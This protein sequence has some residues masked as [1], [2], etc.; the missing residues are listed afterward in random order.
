MCTVK[1][2]NMN[3][4]SSKNFNMVSVGNVDLY[5]SY[6]TVVAFR[7]PKYNLV[8]VENSWGPTTGK[9]LNWIDGGTDKDKRLPY[10]VFDMKLR[11]M[12]KEHGLA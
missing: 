6:E 8:V 11:D 12:L 1:L 3:Q 2:R 7:A 10:G 4:N 9:H 5:F